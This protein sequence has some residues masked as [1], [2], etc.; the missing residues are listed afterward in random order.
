MDSDSDDSLFGGT[1]FSNSPPV[2]R[3]SRTKKT[4]ARRAD[5]PLAAMLREQ[6]KEEAKIDRFHKKEQK[7]DAKNKELQYADMDAEK[8]MKLIDESIAA[9]IKQDSIPRRDYS[10]HILHVSSDYVK[11]VKPFDNSL[12]NM[13]T[14]HLWKHVGEILSNVPIQ[15]VNDRVISAV[16]TEKNIKCPDSIINY[17]IELILTSNEFNVSQNAMD[18]LICLSFGS[19]GRCMSSLCFL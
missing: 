19:S 17:L 16:V 11:P 14:H 9:D 18:N 2:R 12:T 7:I 10:F 4:K 3:S 15:A 8:E 5:D 1:L 6:Q 13:E